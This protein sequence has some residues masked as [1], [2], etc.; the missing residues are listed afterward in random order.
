MNGNSFSRLK[1]R[2]LLEKLNQHLLASLV[3]IGATASIALVSLVLTIL[4]HYAFILVMVSACCIVGAL[5]QYL[6]KL[7]N[8]RRQF[9]SGMYDINDKQ[10]FWHVENVRDKL[11]SRLIQEN[12]CP[13]VTDAC[14]IKSC[15]RTQCL[16]AAQVT[17]L[18]KVGY[19]TNDK[20][21]IVLNEKDAC[22]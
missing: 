1:G 6:R 20:A 15:K 7:D 4:Y 9:M 16:C 10:L 19:D 13:W 22:T 5:L 11:M 3:L 2:A 18:A 12:V 14:N 21:K 17:E 8:L